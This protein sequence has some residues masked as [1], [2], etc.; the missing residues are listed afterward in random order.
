MKGAGVT[1]RSEMGRIFMPLAAISTFASST[2][3]PYGSGGGEGSHGAVR[4]KSISHSLT[5]TDPDPAPD[6]DPSLISKRF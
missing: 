5:G 6:L 2:M 4:S 1:S 3:V